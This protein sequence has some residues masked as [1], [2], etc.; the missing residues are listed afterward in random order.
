MFCDEAHT[1]VC[2]ESQVIVQRRIKGF[3]EASLAALTVA[4]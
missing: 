3:G 2:N 4:A 1:L